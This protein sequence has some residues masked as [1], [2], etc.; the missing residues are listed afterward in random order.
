MVI[1]TG[2]FYLYFMLLKGGPLLLNRFYRYLSNR[3]SNI[4]MHNSFSNNNHFLQSMKW[5]DSRTEIHQSLLSQFYLLV[6]F[7][8][9]IVGISCWW[10]SPQKS[11]CFSG[12]AWMMGLKPL[13]PWSPNS[14]LIKITMKKITAHSFEFFSQ[15]YLAIKRISTT[16][17]F[18]Y[19]FHLTTLDV[20]TIARSA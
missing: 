20:C 19:S 14:N 11:F 6:E 5:V 10:I 18:L 8:T 9:V 7:F 15:K 17:W 16:K 4:T 12:L 13:D 1:I 2:N 3:L